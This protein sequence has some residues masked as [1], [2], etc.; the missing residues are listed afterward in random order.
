LLNTLLL[1]IQFF[2][3]AALANGEAFWYFC[4]HTEVTPTGQF[5]QGLELPLNFMFNIPCIMDQFVKK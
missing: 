1:F 2:S 4:T 5:L 3:T